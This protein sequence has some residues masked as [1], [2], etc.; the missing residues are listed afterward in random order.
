MDKLNGGLMEL[1]LW[2]ARSDLEAQEFSNPPAMN[3]SQNPSAE[4]NVSMATAQLIG[5]V[6]EAGVF[7]VTAGTL[8]R[9][10]RL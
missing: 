3:Q 1:D 10:G 6:S 5:G 9:G 2:K 8:G 4:N 7:A